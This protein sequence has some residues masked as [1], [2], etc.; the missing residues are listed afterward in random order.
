MGDTEQSQP[1]T[2]PD[3][4]AGDTRKERLRRAYADAARDEQFQAEMGEIGCAFDV[5]V[6]D[7]LDEV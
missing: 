5:T 4:S 1:S 7:G 2:D 3:D 6:G